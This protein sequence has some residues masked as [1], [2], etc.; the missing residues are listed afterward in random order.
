[1]M[2]SAL[3]KERREIK[4]AQREAEMNSIPSAGGSE[5]QDPMADGNFEI[6]FTI[7]IIQPLLHIIYQQ[8]SI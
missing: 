4:Q 8:S 5:W 1:M 3:Q 6:F 2:Q 7:I